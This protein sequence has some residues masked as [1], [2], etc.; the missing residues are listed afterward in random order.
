MSEVITKEVITNEVITKNFITIADAQVEDIVLL[1]ANIPYKNGQR[2]TDGE[3]YS[4]YR[5]EGVVFNVPDVSPFVKDHLEGN[6]SSVKLEDKTRVKDAKDAS[7]VIVKT[8]VRAFEFDS[9]RTLTS[10]NALMNAQYS[11]ARHAARMKQLLVIGSSANL[12]EAQVAMLES[13]NV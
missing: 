9:H 5:F 7:G 13:N 3:T 12:T 6:I 11:R 8:T 10:E 1:K 2:K 4:Q